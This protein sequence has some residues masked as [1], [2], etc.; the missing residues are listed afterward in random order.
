MKRALALLVVVAVAVAA[1]VYKT[2]QTALRCPSEDRLLSRG[3]IIDGAVVFAAAELR[4]WHT[5]DPFTSTPVQA[6]TTPAMVRA[7]QPDCCSIARNV[8]DAL[9]DLTEDTRIRT[10]AP[11]LHSY[12]KLQIDSPEL[13]PPEIASIDQIVGIDV[14]GQPIQDWLDLSPVASS[15]EQG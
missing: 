8:P 2:R 7:A 1:V 10:G 14:C 11:A 12:V 3:A 13:L 5:T 15:P 6:A 4:R 9:A